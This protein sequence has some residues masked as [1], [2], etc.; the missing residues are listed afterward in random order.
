MASRDIQPELRQGLEQITIAQFRDVVAPIDEEAANY[1]AIMTNRKPA[2]EF[3]RLVQTETVAFIT[4]LVGWSSK[5]IQPH[6]GRAP[7]ATLDLRASKVDRLIDQH[8]VEFLSTSKNVEVQEYVTETGQAQQ[9]TYLQSRLNGKVRHVNILRLENDASSEQHIAEYSV[10][11]EDIG[12]H[13]SQA[14]KLLLISRLWLQAHSGDNDARQL[15]EDLMPKTAQLQ[16]LGGI[17]L[18]DTSQL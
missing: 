12:Q 14:D 3:A 13:D 18:K 10:G 6:T 1:V 8:G 7:I 16:T 2:G 15:L 4:K 11:F 5:D 17:V 9:F